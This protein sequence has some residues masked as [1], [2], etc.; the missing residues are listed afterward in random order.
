MALNIQE[1]PGRVNAM[2]LDCVLVLAGGVLVLAGGVLV[3][4]GGVPV[5]AG[6]VPVLPGG[7]PSNGAV[8]LNIRELPGQVNASICRP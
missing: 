8:V 2:Q 1:L 5:L 6:G 4:A 3:L 7:V